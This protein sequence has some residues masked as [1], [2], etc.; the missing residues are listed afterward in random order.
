LLTPKEVELD[1]T[2]R[3]TSSNQLVIQTAGQWRWT[4]AYTMHMM[5]TED[6]HK[7]KKKRHNDHKR[8]K[9]HALVSSEATHTKH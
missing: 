5:I 6:N 7:K 2:D 1:K 4:R 9:T 8:N 3:M